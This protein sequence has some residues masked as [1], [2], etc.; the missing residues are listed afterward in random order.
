MIA[1]ASVAWPR[2]VPC[3]MRLKMGHQISAVVVAGDVDLERAR[4]F[5]V[6]I[7]P[8]LDG[9]TLIALEAEYVDAWADRLDIHDAVADRPLLNFRVV[10]Y[11]LRKIASDSPFA[12]IETDYAGGVGEQS[13]A[14]YRGE[15]EIMPPRTARTGTINEALRLIGV[16]RRHARDEFDTI[17]LSRYRNRDDLFHDP[18]DQ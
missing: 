10:H 5:D 9:F 7:V 12:I 4:T 16:R 13:A 17:G 11:I 3:T 6:K 15:E 8:C 1:T 14:V 18:R 2:P